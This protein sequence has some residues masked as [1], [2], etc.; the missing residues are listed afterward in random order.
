MSQLGKNAV[1]GLE[2][3]TCDVMQSLVSEDTGAEVIFRGKEKPIEQLQEI[4]RE[5]APAIK[6]D[7]DGNTWM[8]AKVMGEIRARYD[9]KYLTMAAG[10]NCLPFEEK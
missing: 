3:D 5:M 2:M 10:T 6:G 7:D 8:D 1:V 9:L 4:V